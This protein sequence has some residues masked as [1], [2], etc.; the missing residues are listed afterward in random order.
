MNYARRRSMQ[1][2]TALNQRI[3]DAFANYRYGRA[4]TPLR[5]IVMT[6]RGPLP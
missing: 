6:P 4:L 5:E 1:C 3:I 2:I